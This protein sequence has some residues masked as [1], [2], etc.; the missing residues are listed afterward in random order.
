[1]MTNLQHLQNA[2]QRANTEEMMVLKNG[3]PDNNGFIVVN[4]E[5]GYNIE[6]HENMVTRCSCPHNVFRGVIC[7]HMVKV[8]LEKELNIS[9]LTTNLG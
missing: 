8:S 9:G 5:K 2:I 4:G 7:K 1:M 3:A 6:V